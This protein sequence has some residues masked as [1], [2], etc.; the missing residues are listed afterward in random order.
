MRRLQAQKP[1][2]SVHVDGRQDRENPPRSERPMVPIHGARK[3]ARFGTRQ[4]VAEVA[5][6]VESKSVRRI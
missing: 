5:I 2:R 4:R 3:L 6:W 1:K